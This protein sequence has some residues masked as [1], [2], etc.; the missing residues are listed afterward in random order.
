M[1]ESDSQVKM[2]AMMVT[3]LVT[4]MLLHKKRRKS[5]VTGPL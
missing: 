1:L 5:L 4:G 3:L 2:Y